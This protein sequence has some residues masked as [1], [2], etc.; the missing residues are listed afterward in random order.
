MPPE[1]QGPVAQDFVLVAV[2]AGPSGHVAAVRLASTGEV[3]YLREGQPVLSWNAMKVSDRSV[4]IGTAESNVEITMFD[5]TKP[6]A[7]GA[8]DQAPPPEPYAEPPPD[9][10]MDHGAPE[11]LY[12]MPAEHQ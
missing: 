3:L 4:V 5:P 11:D 6:E 2:A 8:S 1:P 10:G 12:N 7:G 9:M